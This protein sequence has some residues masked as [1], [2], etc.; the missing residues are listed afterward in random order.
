MKGRRKTVDSGTL[1]TVI[2]TCLIK[3]DKIEEAKR[4][5]E[6]VIKIVMAQENACHGV[7]VHVQP[8]Q[9]QRLLIIERWDSEEVF[10]GPHMQTPHMQTF[11]KKAETFL[12]GVAEFSFW[13]EIV[14]AP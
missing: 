13:K 6:A 12:D 4:E 11:L 5:L 8:K 2:I 1:V 7:R 9:P 14:V 3:P 10:T